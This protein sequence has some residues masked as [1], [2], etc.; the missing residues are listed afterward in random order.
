MNMMNMKRRFE[1]TTVTQKMFTDY[2]TEPLPR[3]QVCKYP[4]PGKRPYADLI[5]KNVG[6]HGFLSDPG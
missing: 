2:A 4:L 5:Q 1:E 3:R 6:N